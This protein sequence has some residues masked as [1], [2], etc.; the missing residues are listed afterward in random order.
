MVNFIRTLLFRLIIISILVPGIS[1]FAGEDSESL[2]DDEY[3][4]FEFFLT[5]TAQKQY[6]MLDGQ[7]SPKDFFDTS[8]ALLDYRYSNFSLFIDWSMI[9]DEI[10]DPAEVY[11]MG[12]YFYIN[13]AH[14]DYET[15]RFYIKAGRSIQKDVVDSPYSLFV[16]SEPIPS[17]QIETKYTGDFFFYTN[18]W[19]NLNHNSENT[20]FGSGADSPFW[21]YQ[22]GELDYSYREEYPNGIPWVDR[23]AHFHVYG[24]NLGKWRFG[25]QESAVTFGESF[26][27]EFFLS[28]MIMYFAQLVVDDGAKPW[29][30]YANSK[31]FMGF[32]VDRTTDD[33]YFSSQILIDDING[34]ILPGVENVNQNRLA[35]SIGGYRDFSFG[36]MGFFHGGALKD[37]FG[38]TYASTVNGSDYP[39][40]DYD[41]YNADDIPLYYSYHPYP[42]TYYP[43]VEYNLEDG[44]RMPIDYTQNYIGYK[45]GENNLA[46]LLD[47][48]NE[49]FTRSPHK[50]SLYAALEWVLNG[51]KSPAN[52]WHEY[53]RWTQ[54]PDPTQLLD[55]TVENILTIRTRLDRSINFLG[56]PFSVFA[57]LELGMAFNAMGLEPAHADAEVTEA[58]IYRPQP[59]IN[60]PIYQLSI[61]F[62]YLWRLK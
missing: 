51:A 17:V 24:L 44:T 49:F 10:Y 36:R 48:K 41:E 57:D 15:D 28:P 7:R 23:G 21:D 19:V 27:P 46:F 37:T 39:Y 4:A 25:L 30:E 18:R 50:L 32:F 47:Y 22:D 59:G 2:E 38:A 61:G 35:W 14:V 60:E 33:S 5:G 11:M 55:G 58:W 16:N 40:R 34:D 29:L 56:V 42:Y 26:S 43:D 12:R 8:R 3:L 52:P 6:E 20:Y 13:D 53:D 1:L 31:H 54:I 9:N 45:Y 62:S